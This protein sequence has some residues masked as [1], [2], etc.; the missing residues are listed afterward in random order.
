MKEKKSYI[1][2]KLQSKQKQTLID[3][4]QQFKEKGKTEELIEIIILLNTTTDE[5]IRRLS[6]NL[7]FDIKKQDAAPVLVNAIENITFKNIRK[8][9]VSACWESGLDFSEYLPVFSEL[10][11]NSDF[12]TSIE[13]FTVIENCI[14]SAKIEVIE[15]EIIAT[16]SILNSMPDEIKSLSFIMIQLLEQMKQGKTK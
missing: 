6:G 3:G 14:S 1:V 9:L 10:V 7:L 5:E 15:K 12:E 8:T 2:K 16:K 13:A 11:R 4:I